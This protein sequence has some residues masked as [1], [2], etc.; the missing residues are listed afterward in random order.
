MEQLLRDARIVPS[1]FGTPSTLADL[2]HVSVEVP[3]NGREVTPDRALLNYIQQRYGGGNLWGDN[4]NDILS[5][6]KLRGVKAENLSVQSTD[7]RQIAEFDLSVENLLKL[8]HTYLGVQ[9]KANADEELF[10]AVAEQN[11]LNRFLRGAFNGAWGTLKSNWEM[12]TD[13]IGTLRGIKDALVQISN[14]SLDELKTIVVNGVKGGA[15][16]IKNASGPEIAEK[17]G[18]IVGSAVVE[19]ALGKGAGALLKALRGTRALTAVI[20]KTEHVLQAAKQT[21][22][23]IPIPTVGASIIETTTGE[24]LLFPRGELTKLEDLLK[25]MESRAQSAVSELEETRS[26]RRN[27]ESH[28]VAGG[29]TVELHVG[30]S[31][32]WLNDR[33]RREPNLKFASSFRNE[34]IA[35]RVQGQFVKRYRAEIESW[36]QSGSNVPLTREVTMGDP[37]GI[38]VERG[39]SGFITTNKASVTIVRDSSQQGWHIL[40][41]Y[42]VK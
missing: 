9:E 3:N 31:E 21:I 41:S 13:P 15:E 20:E 1:I 11:E 35:N 32:H 40:T 4:F 19:I 25:P 5:L 39:K 37:T 18:E 27:L 42:P 10:K 30:K 29:H 33:L 23:K 38:V 2:R 12:I 17:A 26:V 8:Q 28:E 6:A 36:L 14:L 34:A 16:W 22:G 24:R 7:G